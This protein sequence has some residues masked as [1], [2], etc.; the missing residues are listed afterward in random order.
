MEASKK[1][2]VS[3]PALRRWELGI[4]EP[5]AEEVKKLAKLYGM[6]GDEALCIDKA[7]DD[8]SELKG[9]ESYSDNLNLEI[10]QSTEEGLDFSEYEDFISAVAKLP[11]GPRKEKAADIVWDIMSHAG[12]VSGYGYIEPSDLEGIKELRDT[13]LFEDFKYRLKQKYNDSETEEDNLEGYPEFRLACNDKDGNVIGAILLS[14]FE[15]KGKYYLII[16]YYDSANYMANEQSID[17][18]L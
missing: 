15:D 10:R 11:K 4:T 3:Y 12:M 14:I 9:W 8:G 18:D 2:G 7:P 13:D 6:T 16:D 1:T 17:E 5:S